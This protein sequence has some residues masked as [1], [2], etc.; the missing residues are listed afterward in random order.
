VNLF[1]IPQ[2]ADLARARRLRAGDRRLV[3]GARPG[4]RPTRGDWRGL[5]ANL[6]RFSAGQLPWAPA[7]SPNSTIRDARGSRIATSPW[8]RRKTS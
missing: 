8:C 6:S 3:P 5:S 2:P 4:G 1:A 7:S